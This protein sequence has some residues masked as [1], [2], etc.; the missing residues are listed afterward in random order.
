M[1]YLG[2]DFGSKRVGIAMSDDDGKMAFPKTVLAN[3]KNLIE[4]IKK[5][6][7]EEKIGAIVLGESKD[8]DM[9]DN[10]I[11]EEIRKFK[12]EIESETFLEVIFEPEFLTSAEAERLQG[13]TKLLDASAAALILKSYLD[14]RAG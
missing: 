8:F 13:K 11:M 3:D 12:T 5:I 7:I 9:K 6:C 14:K 1:K 4:S 10:M 2:I